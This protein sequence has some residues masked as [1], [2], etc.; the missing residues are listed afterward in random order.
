M[1]RRYV[2]LLEDQQMKLVEGV[3]ELYR[4]LRRGERWTGPNIAE[5][6]QGYP[7]VQDVLDSLAVLAPSECKTL[8]KREELMVVTEALGHALV[9]AMQTAA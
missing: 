3:Q 8:Q 6:S 7:L 4:R 1:P 9:V 5:D 2:Q